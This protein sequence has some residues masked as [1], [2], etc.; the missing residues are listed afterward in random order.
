MKISF[1]YILK[2]KRL[3]FSAL[4]FFVIIGISLPTFTQAAWWSYIVPSSSIYQITKGLTDTIKGA[5]YIIANFI[6]SFYL[7]TFL[8]AA[9]IFS[10]LSGT[11]LIWVISVSTNYI[12][13]TSL[14]PVI[15]PVISAG[16]PIV[17]DFANMFVVV[18]LIVIAMA[19]I[20]RIKNY[21]A[22]KLLPRLIVAAILI[23]FS[24]VICGVFIDLSNV[25]MREF[26]IGSQVNAAGN[27]ISTAE[28]GAFLQTLNSAAT[29]APTIFAAKVM[30]NIFFYIMKGIIS[31]LFVF[32][33]LFRIMA[34]W[35]LVL[36]SPLAFASA[37]AP[38]TKGMI[39]DK[40]LHN[41]IQ[42][43]FIGVFGSLFLY[44]GNKV[45]VTMTSQAFP[46]LLVPAGNGSLQVAL[47]QSVTRLATFFVPGAFL[48]IG[49]MFSL[50]L[51]AMGAGFVT[52]NFKKYGS[53]ALG[54]AKS[55]AKEYS[56]R[57]GML[58]AARGVADSVT[59]NPRVNQLR[60]AIWGRG[61]T[62][63]RTKAVADR[64]LN[65]ERERLK[66]IEGIG[67][68]RAEMASAD[69]YKSAAA[70]EKLA[71]KNALRPA[72]E[73]FVRNAI[74]TGASAGEITKNYADWAHLDTEKMTEFR[75][76]NAQGPSENHTA[77]EDRIATMARK[78]AYARMPEDKE[79]MRLPDEEKFD[80]I[81]ESA[82]GL[83]TTTG[84]LS[85]NIDSRNSQLLDGLAEDGKLDKFAKFIEK[86]GETMGLSSVDGTNE[87]ASQMNHVSENFG[88]NI[89][90]SAK[91]K[92]LG[93]A[94]RNQKAIRER[95]ESNA[96]TAKRPVIRATD[97]PQAIREL[98][99]EEYAS[100]SANRIAQHL[101]DSIFDSYD[102]ISNQGTSAEKLSEVNKSEHMSENKR[103]KAKKHI[104]K[105]TRGAIAA[106]AK[107]DDARGD[108]LTNRVAEL[109]T[110]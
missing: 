14:D 101:D 72:D 3:V 109:R 2:N 47:V 43:C 102:F 25:I 27:W 76:K 98:E 81:I 95:A 45:N 46:E 49:L 44:L 75:A 60:D 24:L 4:L 57:T 94:A 64:R 11:L 74:N 93:W 19:T 83:N 6:L 88:S 67:T 86:K 15:N 73:T 9:F 99:N 36:L 38:G 69:R 20:L 34:L 56:S 70:V 97:F 28:I 103:N 55:A 104:P 68:L 40:W 54:A 7:G 84:K 42:W 105:L 29:D 16:W 41:F 39:F 10:F 87:V 96:A 58:G 63:T 61:T 91:K 31:F 8:T 80:R 18:M 62:E 71:K 30:G 32:L 107:G 89:F 22:G 13:Y 106:Y 37:I 82:G 51:S 1:S 92:G 17:R 85:R 77:Y 78:E 12:N 5:G 53:G 23:N 33:F 108:E 110:W 65:P 35:I 66:S 50:S 26:L 59:N 21:E 52:S 48:V 90:S 100:A 79:L